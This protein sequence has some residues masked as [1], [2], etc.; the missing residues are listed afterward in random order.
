M[1]AGP[2]LVVG[3]D[4]WAIEQAAASVAAAGREVARCHEPG[5][6]AFPCNAFIAGRGCPLDRGVAA[7]VTVRARS[8]RI[9]EPGEVG[10]VCS[11]RAGVPVVVAGVGAPGP[12]ATVADAQVPDRGDLVST[13]DSVAA[14]A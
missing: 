10:V 13:C 8:S 6:P 12:F 1:E 4:D 7:V 2:V 3:T 11:A 5:E 14:H 9:V